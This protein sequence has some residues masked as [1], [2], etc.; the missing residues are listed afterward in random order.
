DATVTPSLSP[1]YTIK[2]VLNF[3]TQSQAAFVQ[4]ISAYTNVKTCA[5]FR[6]PYAG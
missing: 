5:V 1:G 2:N 6:L 3:R 4:G